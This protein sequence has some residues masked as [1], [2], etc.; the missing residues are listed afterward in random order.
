MERRSIFDLG[1]PLRLLSH[2]KIKTDHR[3]RKVPFQ[4]WRQ[5]LAAQRVPG[6]D[7]L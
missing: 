3:A 5:H 4:L 6:H 2:C 1:K 7:A